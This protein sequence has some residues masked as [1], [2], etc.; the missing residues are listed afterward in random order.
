MHPPN[1][2]LARIVVLVLIATMISAITAFPTHAAAES[3]K[4][5]A[6]KAQI[7]DIKKRLAAAK[8]KEAE[9]SKEV[10]NLDKQVADLNRQIESGQHDI[11]SLESDIRTMQA[12][13]DQVQAR[14]KQAA[15]ASNARA[16]RLYV[17]GPAVSVAMLF[18]AD[19]IVELTRLQFLMEKSSE[20]DSKI[21]IDTSRL[22]SELQE[23]QGELN[24]IKG[25]LTAQKEWLKTRKNLADSARSEKANA[26]SSVQAEIAKTQAHV[27]GLE[28]DSKALEAALRKISSSSRGGGSTASGEGGAA[29]SQGFFR[30]VSGSV[31]SPYG[32]RWG[33]THTGVDIDGNTGDPIRAV[34][35]G[36]IL[37]VSCGGGYGVCTL[38]D[39]G[40]GMVTLYAHMSRKAV[41]GGRVSGGQLIGYVGCSGSCTGSHLHLE[42]RVNGATRNPM[43]YF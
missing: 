23:K 37:G 14:F 38:I 36:T 39:H 7:A 1:P 16:K 30:P 2:R 10:E 15:D 41:S 5:K 11:S 12:Q 29:S 28:R 32:P 21:I 22:R 6:T 35:D 4:L 18:S 19:S 42:L 33:R 9:I 24:K 27:D 26:L 31:T 43:A 34:K 20:Q 8:G 40:G 25:S 13:I 17:Q 3:E